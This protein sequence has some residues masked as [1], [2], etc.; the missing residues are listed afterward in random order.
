MSLGRRQKELLVLVLRAFPYSPTPQYHV[1]SLPA[2]WV[3]GT[4]RPPSHKG[5]PWVLDNGQELVSSSGVLGR[6]EHCELRVS[7]PLSPGAV[8]SSR[9]SSTH[10]SLCSPV[11]EHF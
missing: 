3:E 5:V 11:G 7:E 1:L 9:G 4:P 2:C 8:L 6:R 10:L